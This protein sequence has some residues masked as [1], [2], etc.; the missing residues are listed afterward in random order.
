MLLSIHYQLHRVLSLGP[1]PETGAWVPFNVFDDVLGK[2][3]RIVSLSNIDT[4]SKFVNMPNMTD[5]KIDI[6]DAAMRVL[7]RY[8]LRKTTMKDIAEEAGVARQTVYNAFANKDV[9]LCDLIHH[10]GVQIDLQTREQWQGVSSLEAKLWIFFENSLMVAF[11]TM[12]AS[13]GVESIEDS[14]SAA[15]HQAMAEVDV[16]KQ[17]LLRDLF[18]DHEAA[19]AAQEISVEQMA[20][21]VRLTA[22]GYKHQARD[23]AHLRSL[24]QILTQMVLRVAV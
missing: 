22:V 16:L 10:A 23:E 2:C 18:S 4:S 24:L 6:L 21:W 7:T 5:S 14:L 12:Q 1:V 15:G 3:T 8:G 11:R 9:L 13:G 17:A 19:L 20:E